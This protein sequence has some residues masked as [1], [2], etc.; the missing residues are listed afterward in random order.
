MIFEKK[1][2]APSVLDRV[3]FNSTEYKN[4][5]LNVIPVV[6]DRDTVLWYHIELL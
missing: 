2:Q 6:V 5:L 4:D 3:Y 1:H